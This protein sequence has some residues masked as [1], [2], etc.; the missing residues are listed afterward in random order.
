MDKDSARARYPTEH[1]MESA[2][3]ERPFGRGPRDEPIAVH[4][5]QDRDTAATYERLTYVRLVVDR[6]PGILA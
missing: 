6:R 3:C 4:R 1:F 2:P 5:S